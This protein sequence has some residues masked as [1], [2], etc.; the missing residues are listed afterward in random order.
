ML[1]YNET[2]LYEFIKVGKS[3]DFKNDLSILANKYHENEIWKLQTMLLSDWSKV[4]SL[5]DKDIIALI[6]TFTIL[7]KGGSVSFVI[8][9]YRLLEKRTINNLE[10][11]A[12]WVLANTKNKYEPFGTNN[13][14]AKS[15]DE[16]ALL[17]KSE[18]NRKEA[19]YKRIEDE[20][21]ASK[22]RKKEDATEK[23]SK[24]VRR[25][26]I[27]AI[28]ALLAKGANIHYLDKNGKSSFDYAQELG[29]LGYLE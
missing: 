1:L 11:V 28:Q 5:C 25:K 22:E 26:D 6:K 2:L 27:K 3:S 17:L 29:L 12:N 14:G 19:T 24:A 21:L 10:E 4:D 8:W 9:L 18:W 7:G 20:Q 13:Y 16:Y 23:L 15:I